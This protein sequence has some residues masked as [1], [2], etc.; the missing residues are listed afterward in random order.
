MIFD[1]DFYVKIFI[2]AVI[3]WKLGR[4]E[5]IICDVLNDLHDLQEKIK[6]R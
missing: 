1:F 6:R 4:L 5:R 3:G 2:A